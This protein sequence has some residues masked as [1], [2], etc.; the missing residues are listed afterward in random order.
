M[1]SDHK[2]KAAAAKVNLAAVVILLVGSNTI[3]L[4]LSPHALAES[5]CCTCCK[6]QGPFCL[7]QFSINH[8]SARPTVQS[9]GANAAG[10]SPP[11]PLCQLCMMACVI[12]LVAGLHMG[13]CARC[14]CLCNWHMPPAVAH[15]TTAA[16][17]YPPSAVD[18]HG[19]SMGQAVRALCARMR[20]KALCGMHDC[21][22]PPAGGISSWLDS[23]A[24]S[25]AA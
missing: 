19:T 25:P 16:E 20:M 13:F 2:K 7:W 4:H 11:A 21:R 9:A 6:A 1:P 10:S 8:H 18:K 15:S 12:M 5:S 14:S 24:A 3:M 23:K 17:T 22:M